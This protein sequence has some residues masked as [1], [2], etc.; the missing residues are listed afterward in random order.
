MEVAI[1]APLTIVYEPLF[2]EDVAEDVA[3]AGATPVSAPDASA[4][5]VAAAAAAAAALESDWE[6]DDDVPLAALV[7]RNAPAADPTLAEIAASERRVAAAKRAAKFGAPAAV[8]TEAAGFKT[9]AAGFKTEAAGF[10]PSVMRKVATA[11][12]SVLSRFIGAKPAPADAGFPVLSPST[13]KKRRTPRFGGDRGG[14]GSAR[15]AFLRGENN[16]AS[17]AA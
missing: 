11:A 6:S 8:K 5:P 15:V 9:E 13:P 10:E 14:G 16:N 17:K 4:P 7:P 2:A 3:Y 12:S 1:E